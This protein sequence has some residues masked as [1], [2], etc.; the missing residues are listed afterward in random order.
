MI[1]I[2]QAPAA[3][4]SAEAGRI[5]V[6]GIGE[7]P[8][9]AEIVHHP[10]DI[11]HHEAV[12]DDAGEIVAPAH[13][14][15]IADAYDET[16]KTVRGPLT[17]AEIAA[18]GSVEWVIYQFNDAI[19]EKGADGARLHSGLVA[20]QVCDAFA[21]QGLD[22]HRYG[23]FCEDDEFETVDTGE[24]VDGIPETVQQKTGRKVLGLRYTE[25]LAFE[26]AYVRSLLARRA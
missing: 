7:T 26:A 11:V 18:W 9:P 15:T 25:C 1:I 24:I 6:T 16:K 14:E 8:R 12:L 19:A 5:V 4:G 3:P 23:L 21:A 2:H 20:Q 13:D 17:E 22:A 10:A